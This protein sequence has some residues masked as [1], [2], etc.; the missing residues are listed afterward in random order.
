MSMLVILIAG[1]TPR[2]SIVKPLKIVFITLLRVYMSPFAITGR[3]HT[4]IPFYRVQ[5]LDPSL[6]VL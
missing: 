5:E 1:V 2:P 6:Q 4:D 3:I